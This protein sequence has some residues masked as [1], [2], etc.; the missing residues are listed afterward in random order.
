MDILSCVD[1]WGRTVVLTESVWSHFLAE[2]AEL[3]GQEGALHATITAPG[4]VSDDVE[5]PERVS[6][7]RSGV[8]GRPYRR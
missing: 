6:Y 5:L 8:L 4:R 1:R 2:H 7:Y 3:T